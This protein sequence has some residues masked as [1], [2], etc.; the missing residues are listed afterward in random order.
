MMEWSHKRNQRTKKKLLIVIS[1]FLLRLP[2]RRRLNIIYALIRLNTDTREML[3]KSSMHSDYVSANGDD[4]DDERW[5]WG[6][7]KFILWVVKFKL[8]FRL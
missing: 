4:D 3:S 2:L 6:D 1:S 7:K 5:M 8:S